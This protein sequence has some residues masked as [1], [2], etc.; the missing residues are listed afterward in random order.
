MTTDNKTGIWWRYTLLLA[1][2]IFAGPA[3]HFTNQALRGHPLDPNYFW[4]KWSPLGLF[5][6]GL[7]NGNGGANWKIGEAKANIL[8]AEQ[9]RTLPELQN[10]ALQLVNRDRNINKL[11]SITVDPILNDAAQRHAED[12]L[13]RRYFNH[14]SPEGKTPRDRF[15][16]AGGSSSVGVGENIAYQGTQGLGFTYGIAE[17]LQRGWMYSNGHRENLL[18]PEYKKFGYGIAV[19]PNG[20]VFAVQM[21]SN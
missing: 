14:V 10:F 21:F 15:L 18:T 11:K 17:E 16:D 20:R 19:S 5:G 3:A 8:N 12:M 4:T 9:Q 6:G 1:V 7:Y 13:A 2:L